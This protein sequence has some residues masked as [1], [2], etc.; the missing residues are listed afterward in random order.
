[1]NESDLIYPT[2]DDWWSSK[3]GDTTPRDHFWQMVETLVSL[4]EDNDGGYATIMIK[5][6]INDYLQ[7]AWTQGNQASKITKKENI[8][9]KLARKLWRSTSSPFIRS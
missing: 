7:T 9:G 5:Q 6:A 3:V 2:F 1:M 4:G 8:Y